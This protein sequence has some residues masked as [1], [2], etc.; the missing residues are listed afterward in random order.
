[1]TH[2]CDENCEYA[3]EVAEYIRLSGILKAERAKRE[4]KD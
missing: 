3:R 1:M 4:D 2:E